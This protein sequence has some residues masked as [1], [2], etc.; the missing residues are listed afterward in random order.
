MPDLGEFLN[1]KV[2]IELKNS[3]VLVGILEGFDLHSNISL[4]DI[5][6]KNGKKRGIVRGDVINT[7]E[8]YL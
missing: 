4:R 2:R 8:E 3:G 5:E 6:C 1:K 7:I